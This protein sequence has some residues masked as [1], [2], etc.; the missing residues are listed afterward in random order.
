MKFSAKAILGITLASMLAGPA[1]AA[2]RDPSG[3][4]T[5]PNGDVV[6]VW[7]TDDKLY[8]RITEGK[9][10]DFEM[11]HGMEAND[12]EDRWEGRKMK[13]PG[14][15]GFFTFNGRVVSDE[16]TLTIRGC[17]LGNSMCDSEV[18]ERVEE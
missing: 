14:M 6:R 1:W 12:D 13:H 2:A 7:I 16:S 5:R 3:T 9:K 8:C 11:C 18:W 4:Y 17:A 10:V 15:P